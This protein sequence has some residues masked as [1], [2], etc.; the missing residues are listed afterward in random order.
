MPLIIKG[1]C[2]Y[3]GG[4][5]DT[6][7]SPSE[8]LA[9][10]QELDQ[11]PQLFL[12]EQPSGTTGLARRLNPE[13]FYLAARWDY[14]VLSKEE[15]LKKR[16]I[17]RN[18]KNKKYIVAQPCDWGPH[19]DTNR[20]LDVSPGVMTALELQTDDEIE[21]LMPMRES[22][23]SQLGMTVC[24]SSGHGKYI[25]GASGIVDEV[26]EARKIVPAVVKYLSQRGCRAIEFHDNTSQD[27]QTNLE[28]ITNFHNA[29]ERQLDISVHLNCFDGTGNGVE[30]LYVSQ[31]DLASRVSANI[32]DVAGIKDRGA[33]YND[34]LWF[35]NQ[36]Q[37]P[38]ILIE[39]IFCDHAGDCA[40]YDANFDAIC[41]AIADAIVG[42]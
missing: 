4:P 2:S 5:N 36:C 17:I 13:K 14:D 25:R 10:I 23:Q 19:E 7:V 11:A 18:P 33:K 6:G 34:G 28:T 1:K 37:E 38:A 3:F 9:L 15:I 27:Q 12:P 29:Q 42:D 41:M 31:E 32:A 21:A 20:V 35:L 30:C 16:V 40:A 8:G 22:E 26:D 39:V 24:I